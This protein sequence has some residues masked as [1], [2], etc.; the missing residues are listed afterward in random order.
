MTEI[1]TIDMLAYALGVVEAD[2][3]G[4]Y[5]PEGAVEPWYMAPIGPVD[6][7]YPACP[8]LRRSLAPGQE[9][10]Q[11][12]G[13]IYPEA[14]DVCGWCVRVWRARRARGEDATTPTPAAPRTPV[15]D[16][17]HQDTPA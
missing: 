14:G 7:L 6:H 8:G 3:R 2:L 9:P 10:V 4:R 13:S 1:G 12:R 15:Q 17:S 11:G 16:T 5:G